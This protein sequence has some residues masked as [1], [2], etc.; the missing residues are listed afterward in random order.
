MAPPRTQAG[1]ARRD[2]Q[3]P[4]NAASGLRGWALGTAV[5]A[6]AVALVG[7]TPS[8]PVHDGPQQLP[9]VNIDLGHPNTE[10]QVQLAMT[11][12][13]RAT[14]LMFRQQLAPNEGMLFAFPEPAKQCFWM[15]NTLIPLAAAF[16]SDG[17]TVVNI[18]EMKP[19]SVDLHCSA[20]PVRFVLEM[21]QGW[22]ARHGIGRGSQLQLL[23]GQ[24]AGQSEVVSGQVYAPWRNN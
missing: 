24:S 15:K 6:V 8:S 17:G 10:I 3:A 11:E 21:N 20:S 1:A 13:Q 2:P 12:E 16:V 7:C 19:G 9:M 23:E 18:A 22:F 14:G 5:M 4:S